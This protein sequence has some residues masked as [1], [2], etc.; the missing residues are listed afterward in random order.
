MACVYITFSLSI[1]L[2]DEHLACF[3]VLSVVNNSAWCLQ[4]SDFRNKIGRKYMVS[5]MV[6]NLPAV[7]E[8]WVWSLG[9]EDPLEKRMATQSSILAWRIP[10]TEEPDRLQSTGLQRVEHDWVTNT[11]AFTHGIKSSVFNFL[12]KLHAIV[13]SGCISIPASTASGF[14]FLHTLASV[15]SCLF[16]NLNFKRWEVWDHHRFDLQSLDE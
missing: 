13:H 6:K 16:Y 9:R 5:Q 11:F 2:S 14:P 15:I 7:P 3:H 4:D 8:T 12:R 10:W 1:Y